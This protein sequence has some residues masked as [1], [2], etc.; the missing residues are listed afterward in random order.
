MLCLSSA[1]R[2]P[3]ETVMYRD[4]MLVIFSYLVQSTVYSAARNLGETVMY[5]DGMLAIFSY[6]YCLSAV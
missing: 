3:G 1:A 2:S 5:M 6:Q 4:G